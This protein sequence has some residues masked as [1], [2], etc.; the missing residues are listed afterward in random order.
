MRTKQFQLLTDINLVWDFMVETY[1]WKN[2]RGR[3]AP[4]FEYAFT[5]SWMDT[6]YSFLDRLWFDGDKVVAFVY[7][8]NP[9]TDIYFNVRK[10]YEFLADELVYYA[11]SNMPHFNNEQQFVLFDGQQFLKDAAAKRGFKQVYEWNELV[12]DF[13]FNT[14]PKNGEVKA[15]SEACLDST[16]FKKELN[17]EL[18]QGYHFVEPKDIDIVKCSKLCW[19]GFGHGERGDFVGWDKYDDSLEWTPAKS[20]KSGWGRFLSPSPHDSSQYNIVIADE[21]EEYVC[22][23]GMWWVPQNQLAYMEP[24]CT[25]P[26]HRKRGLASAALTKHYRTLKPLGATH[27]T[28][29]GDPFY[30][31][32]GYGKGYHCTIWR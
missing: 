22:F 10:G 7:Y 9:V 14:N 27:M 1:D 17:Y 12:F 26:D 8:E 21:N 30:Q 13:G 24:L 6:S 31:K 18:P 28:G 4:F 2:D 11:I 29:G 25:H 15:L 19:Y 16:Y 5:S 3:A 23:S 20:H 32:L